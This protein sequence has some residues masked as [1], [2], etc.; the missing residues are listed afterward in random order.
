[1]ALRSALAFRLARQWVLAYW[2]APQLG[3]VCWLVQPSVPQLVE[4]QLPSEPE[5]WS[6]R[7]LVLQLAGR[8]WLLEPEYWLG[9]PLEP[10]FQSVLPCAG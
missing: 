9:L 4:L 5:Y 2:S 3:L 6:A 10:E 1:M 8:R 7:R